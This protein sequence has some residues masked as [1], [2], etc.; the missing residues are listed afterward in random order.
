MKDFLDKFGLSELFAYL[1]P[2]AILLASVLLWVRADHLPAVGREKDS[3]QMFVLV[4]FLVIASYTLGL[5]VSSWSSWGSAYYLRKVSIHS[6]TWKPLRRLWLLLVGSV[7]AFRRQRGDSFIEQN[8]RISDDLWKLIRLDGLSNLDVPWDRLVLYRTILADRVGEK[9]RT[10]LAEA[11]SLHRRFLFAQAVALVCAL[12]ALQAGLRLFLGAVDW[13]QDV[14]PAIPLFGLLGL[15]AFGVCSSASLRWAAGHW[16]EAE[17]ILTCS[18]C[19]L[20]DAARQLEI[21]VLAYKKW[22]LRGRPA[23]TPE[24]DWREAEAEMDGD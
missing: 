4:A 20:L 3:W 24:Q 8:K 7:F 9:A 21:E 1:F 19:K 6:I 2:G 18:L 5:I 12:L 16:W 11:D 23:G 22:Q 15:A 17:Y 10:V 13:G 14:L